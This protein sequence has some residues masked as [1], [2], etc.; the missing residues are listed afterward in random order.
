[1]LHL[2]LQNSVSVECGCLQSSLG[3][4]LA[5][6]APLNDRLVDPVDAQPGEG[7]PD[8]QRPEGVPSQ[9][10]GVEAVGGQERVA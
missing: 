6:D 1:M 9:R 7:A 3:L 10:V 4:R 8:A 5:G 2:G